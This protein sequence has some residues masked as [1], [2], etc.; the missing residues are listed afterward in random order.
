MNNIYITGI[1]GTGK[2]T[3]AHALKERGIK[4]ISMDEVP[5]LYFWMENKQ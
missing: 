1:S 2:T 3:I 5:D 4:T